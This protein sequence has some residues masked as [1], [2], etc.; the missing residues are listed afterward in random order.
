MKKLRE[1]FADLM[2]EIGSKDKTL[3]V[4]VGDISHGILKP[5][6]KKFP[7]RYYNIGICEPSIVNLAAGLKKAGLNPVVH[8]IAPFIS[9]RSYEQIK[10]DFGYQKL[11]INFVT[12]GGS[13]D[14]SKL[15]CTHHCYSDVSLLSH[16][17]NSNIFIPGSNI[18][19]E[20]LFKNAY[21]KNSI[22]YFRLTDN[23]HEVKINKKILIGKAI[24]MT[25]G[26][27]VTL[28]VIGS[29]LK[30]AQKAYLI[31]KKKKISCEI[32]YFP[33]IKPFDDET[34]LKSVKKTKKFI[35]IEELSA[36]DGLYNLCLKTIK[37][38]FLYKSDQIAIKKFIHEY[39]TYDYLCKITGLNSENIVD[40]VK[41]L[42]L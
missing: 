18:E 11:G 13:F 9:E 24:K 29:Q 8:T 37:G 3:V 41:S 4:L 31:L 20:N 28:A 22:N 5:F 1:T 21:K 30:N 17:E 19:F 42:M 6:A 14:Y 26:N 23:S 33:T 35:S 27:D 15:G 34:F 12:I 40:R 39:G 36:S 38:N 10:L 32:I 2:L 7:D 25:N 16:F